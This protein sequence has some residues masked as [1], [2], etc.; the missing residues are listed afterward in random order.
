MKRF[1]A[2]LRMVGSRLKKSNKTEHCEDVNKEEDESEGESHFDLN[3]GYET[4]DVTLSSWTFD[5]AHLDGPEIDSVDSNAVVLD[6][7]SWER[8]YVGDNRDADSMTSQMVH[9]GSAASSECYFS[10]DDGADTDAEFENAPHPT[11]VD[12]EFMITDWDQFVDDRLCRFCRQ[13]DFGKVLGVNFSHKAFSGGKYHLMLRPRK[14]FPVC[15]VN[16]VLREPDADCPL[17]GLF[18]FLA[19]GTLNTS[20]PIYLYAQ[21]FKYWAQSSFNHTGEMSRDMKQQFITVKDTMIFR[22]THDLFEAYEGQSDMY[23]SNRFTITLDK[24]SDI[25]DP[26]LQLIVR[27]TSGLIDWNIIID[28]LDKC[29]SN[30]RHLCYGTVDI[31]AVLPIN[32]IDCKTRNIVE[33]PPDEHY[34]TLS[35]VVSELSLFYHQDWIFKYWYNS[36]NR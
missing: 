33:L 14:G 1:S 17:C 11:S 8:V 15:R 31:F 25:P 12:P 21:S 27:D 3:G 30:H 28:W 24:S 32:V 5:T 18:V 4:N 10:E 16:T 2:K 20:M 6:R 35:Y 29:N 34:V 7:T 26:E 19:G 23:T 13:I 22:L 9:I 36:D